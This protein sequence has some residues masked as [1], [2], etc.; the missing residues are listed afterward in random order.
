LNL[1]NLRKKLGKIKFLVNLEVSKY[2]N[3]GD[4]FN[5]WS[6]IDDIKELECNNKIY[7]QE[8]SYFYKDNQKIPH[9]KAIWND[10][11]QKMVL[12][13]IKESDIC[14]NIDKITKD[15]GE[16]LHMGFSNKDN[17]YSDDNFELFLIEDYLSK[18]L[19]DKPSF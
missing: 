5:K 9:P 2:E 15:I 18:G 3:N 7:Y 1:K 8:Y 12:M 13:P 14:Y 10:N 11:M 6:L 16:E 17:D 19:R 4:L